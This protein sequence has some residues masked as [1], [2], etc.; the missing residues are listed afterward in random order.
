M[1]LG[2]FQPNPKKAPEDKSRP[3]Q[4]RLDPGSDDPIERE[5]ISFLKAHM[6]QGWTL[7]AIV[8]ELYRLYTGAQKP[9]QVDHADFQQMAEALAWIRQQIEDGFVVQVP[10]GQQP[11]R[12][13][14]FVAPK[15]VQPAFKR[16][17]EHGRTAAQLDIDED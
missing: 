1:S 11:K 13:Q 17:E 4:F 6:A 15:H 12:G 10:Q 16:F 7:R 2:R 8:K 14:P 3:Y 9:L 5:L